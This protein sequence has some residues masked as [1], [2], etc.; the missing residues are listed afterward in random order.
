MGQVSERRG[1]MY[2]INFDHQQYH[3][4]SSRSGSQKSTGYSTRDH[5]L[6]WDFN[7]AAEEYVACLRTKFCPSQPTNESKSKSSRR[8][9]SRPAKLLMPKAYSSG[10]TA[11]IFILCQTFTQCLDRRTAIASMLEAWTSR[12]GARIPISNAKSS[13]G[14]DLILLVNSASTRIEKQHGI[15][16]AQLIPLTAGHP[17]DLL[18]FF[19]F[20]SQ[21]HRCIPK[22]IYSLSVE[23]VR[24]LLLIT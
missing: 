5:V 14:I 3:M 15:C 19:T 4:R 2:A 20:T 13:S 24:S 22:S 10:N 21:Q 17:Q 7:S 9:S 1:C 6:C 16:K 11:S 8:A 23:H 12:K 18:F